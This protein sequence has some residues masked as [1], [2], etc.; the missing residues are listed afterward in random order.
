M[1]CDAPCGICPSPCSKAWWCAAGGSFAAC[2]HEV[3]SVHLQVLCACLY[4]LPHACFLALFAFKNAH[5]SL[6]SFLKMKQLILIIVFTSLFMRFER[7]TIYN[8]CMPP[9]CE[10]MCVTQCTLILVFEVPVRGRYTACK[11][12][13]MYMH[14][15]T[16]YAR[17]IP[18]HSFFLTCLQF[19]NFKL[20]SQTHTTRY[21]HIH[22]CILG[23]YH[24]QKL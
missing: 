22:T 4:M 16:W 21:V 17:I 20:L 23:T 8:A 24:I 9:Y 7:H 19:R 12:V 2:A 13:C 18:N 10:H 14:V 1:Y 3:M 5:A 11:H 15:Y 6:H